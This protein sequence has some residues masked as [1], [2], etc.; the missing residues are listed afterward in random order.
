M[1]GNLHRFADSRFLHIV[2][3][4]GED[5]FP[6]HIKGEFRIFGQVPC[7]ACSEKNQLHPEIGRKMS[8]DFF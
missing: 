7:A 8:G 5:G 6:F 1:V 3:P 4:I 2:Y